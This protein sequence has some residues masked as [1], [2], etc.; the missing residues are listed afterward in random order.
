MSLTGIRLE[1]ESEL[2]KQMLLKWFPSFYTYEDQVTP[3]FVA[4]T[5]QEVGSFQ[6]KEPI[7]IFMRIN[8]HD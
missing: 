2:E 8:L 3:I 1:T 7:A 4:G 5:K 6:S